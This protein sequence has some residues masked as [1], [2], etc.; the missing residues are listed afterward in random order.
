MI[1]RQIFQLDNRRARPLFQHNLAELHHL[2]ERLNNEPK[3]AAA[4]DSLR[5]SL[6]EV[7][8]EATLKKF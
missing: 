5:P 2:S 3:S 4:A 1:T 6:V 8:V 7:E